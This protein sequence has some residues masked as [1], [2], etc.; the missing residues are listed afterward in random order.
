MKPTK[1]RTIF[2]VIAL[3][4]NLLL[5]LY[6]KDFLVLSQ[7]LTVFYLLSVLPTFFLVIEVHSKAMRTIAYIILVLDIFMNIIYYICCRRLLPVMTMVFLAVELMYF[8]PSTDQLRKDKLLT[9]ICVWAVTALIFVTI[10]S[11]VIILLKYM[12]I[13]ALIRITQV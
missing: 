9:K 6:L 2:F 11:L 1:S 7:T 5:G 3:T 12:E 10:V 8:I 4:Y 13:C